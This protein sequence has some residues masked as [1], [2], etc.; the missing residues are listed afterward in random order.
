MPNTRTGEDGS[1]KLDGVLPGQQSCIVHSDGHQV[2]HSIAI[3][4]GS[5]C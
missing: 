1:F 5:I 3:R 2:T 4:V